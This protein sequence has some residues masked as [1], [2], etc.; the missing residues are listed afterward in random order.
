MKNEKSK[1]NAALLNRFFDQELEPAEQAW[2]SDHLKDC[3]SCQR[4]IQDSQALSDLFEESLD[5]KLS[6]AGLDKLE[7]NVTELA[8]KNR[9]SIQIKLKSLFVSE[10]FL[11]PAS[12][13]AAI[14]FIFLSVAEYNSSAAGPSA[15]IK[16]CTGEVSSVMII[17]TP[18]SRQT[19]IWFN[20]AFPTV[21]PEIQTSR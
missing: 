17:E 9:N 8:R 4:A 2:F 7:K 5:T 16:S 15:L 11:I 20:E 19:I 3:R 1:C 18:K 12:V 14:F 10:K 21:P 6:Q 13:M